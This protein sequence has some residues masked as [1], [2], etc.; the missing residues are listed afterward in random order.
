MKCPECDGKGYSEG[1]GCPGFKYIRMNCSICKGSGEFPEDMIFDKARG[2]ALKETRRE[3]Y[4]HMGRRAE[5][6]G[7]SVIDLSRME[8][9]YF[10]KGEIT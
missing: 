9:G 3:P 7:I 6:M 4:V 8:R 5:K 1:I 2:A 10:K